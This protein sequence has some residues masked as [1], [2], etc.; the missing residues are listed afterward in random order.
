MIVAEELRFRMSEVPLYTV[1]IRGETYT[2]LGFGRT[3]KK[4]DLSGLASGFLSSEVQDSGFMVYGLWF[5]V[6]GSWFMVHGR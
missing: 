3:S 2:L 5:M 4:D 6:E 1:P